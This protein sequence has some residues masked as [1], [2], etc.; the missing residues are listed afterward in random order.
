MVVDCHHTACIDCVSIAQE[1]VTI[2]ALDDQT[3]RL[4]VFRKAAKQLSRAKLY[5]RQIRSEKTACLYIRFKPSLEKTTYA[6]LSLL[7]Q[8][9]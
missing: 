1:T 7:F 2:M 4:T 8:H 6:C 5:R 9:T 3:K